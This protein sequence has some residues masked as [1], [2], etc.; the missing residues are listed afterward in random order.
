MELPSEKQPASPVTGSRPPAGMP[1]NADRSGGPPDQDSDLDINDE[2]FRRPAV[3]ISPNA[4]PRELSRGSTIDSLPPST[5]SAEGEGKKR[6]KN[7]L[8]KRHSSPLQEFK[9][10]LRPRTAFNAGAA[11]DR[12]RAESPATM[13]SVDSPEFGKARGVS[14]GPDL[15][16]NKLHGVLDSAARHTRLGWLDWI[17]RIGPR[18]ILTVLFLVVAGLFV[19]WRFFGAFG[20][21]AARTQGEQEKQGLSAEQRIARGQAAVQ[22]FLAAQTIPARLPLVMDPD[23]AAPRMR[24]FYENLRGQDP[25]ITAWD[26]GAPVRSSNGDWLP[27]IFTDAAGRKVTVPLG[28]TETGCVVDWENFVAFGDVP[29]T[30]FCVT[31]PGVPKSLRVR[32]RRVENYAAAYPKE[33]WQSY[34]IEHR[35]GGPRLTAYASRAG[36]YSQT[37][38]ELVPGEA[39]QCALLYL[40][41]V[42]NADKADPIIEGVIRT[43]WQDE[44]T[45]WSGP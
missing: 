17:D 36:R 30:D 21:E 43:R 37:L 16:R 27:F 7:P 32:L 1:G 39:W 25:K 4:P 34:E 9:R 2:V 29:W 15:R 11:A 18:T 6:R 19:A 35:S 3:V 5:A 40:R 10:V 41:W 31:R 12:A 33:T 20:G 22:A 23:R 13:D 45:S 38:S 44:A 14:P 26:V 28:E 8:E 24:E 42:G